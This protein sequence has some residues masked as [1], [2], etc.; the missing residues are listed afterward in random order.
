MNKGSWARGTLYVLTKFTPM[1]RV[2]LLSRPENGHL[3]FPGL[4]RPVL[5]IG[6]PNKRGIYSGLDGYILG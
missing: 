4:S 5:K 6:I 2:L 1:P 3:D